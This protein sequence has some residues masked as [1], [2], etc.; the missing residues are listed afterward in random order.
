MATSLST[1]GPTSKTRFLALIRSHNPN[2]ISIGSAAFAQMTVE[3][4]YTL[5]WDAPFSQKFPLPMGIWTPAIEY[6]VPW[7]HQ[8]PQSKRNPDL[9]SRFRR[10]TSVTDRQTT[11]LGR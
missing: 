9:F 6:M 7:A 5:Q 11:L 4:P 3:C 2:G 8:N 1:C 10:L